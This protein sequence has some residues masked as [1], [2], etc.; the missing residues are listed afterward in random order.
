MASWF[1]RPYSLIEPLCSS[2]A[3]TRSQ[4]IST[5]KCI[6]SLD[7]YCW[8]AVTNAVAHAAAE[9]HHPFLIEALAPIWRLSI[10]NPLVFQ[11]RRRLHGFGLI[12]HYSVHTG[13]HHY[14]RPVSLLATHLLSQCVM[15]EQRACAPNVR[16]KSSKD[17]LPRNCWPFDTWWPPL[18]EEYRRSSEMYDEVLCASKEDLVLLNVTPSSGPFSVSSHHPIFAGYSENGEKEY[19]AVI[20]VDLTS[21]WCSVPDGAS[22]VQ[23]VDGQGRRQVATSFQVPVLRFSPEYYVDIEDDMASKRTDCSG[24]VYWRPWCGD[25]GTA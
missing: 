22:S 18:P 14:V 21:L 9:T 13:R 17:S 3:S 6:R 5:L 1:H 23:Y 4:T 8:E 25:E 12:R 19:V 10:I 16:D 2:N 15:L 7:R 24:P 11:S 20:C